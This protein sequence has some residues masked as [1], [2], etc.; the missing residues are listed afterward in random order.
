MNRR[1]Y[2][3]LLSLAFVLRLSAQQSMSLAEAIDYA[4]ANSPEVRIANLNI[5][6]AEWRVKENKSIALPHLALGIDYNY[7][8]QQP[9][10]PIEALGF[11][12]GEPGQKIT[13]AL[14]K[15]LNGKIELN[16]LLFSN[17]Y[18]I[19]IKGARMY[20]EY[21][22]LQLNAARE[23]VRNHVRDAYLPALLFTKAVE[24]LDSNIQNQVELVN[25]TKAILK[26]GFA[27][28]LDVD[29][30]EYI[31]SSLQIRRETQVRQQ[32]IVVN[33]LKYQLNIPV[34]EVVTVSDDLD[35]LLAEY[36]SIDP[37]EEL[38]YMNRPD[39]VAI[40]KAQELDQ[41]QV[42]LYEKDWLP[43]LSFFAS[44]NPGFQG[45]KELFWIPSALAGVSLRMNIYDG[46][47]SRA[48]QERATISALQTEEQKHLMTTGFDLEVENA[49]VQ[50]NTA[51]QQ[52]QDQ[53]HNLDLARRIHV[54]FRNKI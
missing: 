5:K 3:M 11:E 28:Q 27:E 44:Y 13:F 6:D 2:L 29:R 30:L 23:R 47:W 15:S 14:Q 41:M 22:T 33:A 9:A 25:E 52:V 43:T 18:L 50:Y 1:I 19:G 16:Q 53:E 39:Y 20:H 12:G 8:I 42:Q 24:V 51:L 26:A 34:S 35:A 10:L 45:N 4:L 48:K 46:G 38:N 40:L 17:E 31:L 54:T 36:A 21:V 49:R 7:Y 32:E 37:N